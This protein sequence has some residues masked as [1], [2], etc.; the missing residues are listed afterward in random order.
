MIHETFM[1]AAIAEAQAAAQMGDVPVGAVAVQQGLIIGRGR[2]RKE[3]W[4]DPTAHAEML[5]LRE[6]AQHVESWRL[7]QVT[8]YSTLEPCPMCAGALIQARVALLVYG[9][10]D[11]K[12]GAAGSWLNLLQ[13]PL[14]NHRVVVIRGV[15]ADEIQALMGDFFAKLREGKGNM[16]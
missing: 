3:A 4:Q 9:A 15:L 7:P 16:T 11:P 13:A 14:L 8:L 12:T 10:D 1:R 6:A 2:N 5:A